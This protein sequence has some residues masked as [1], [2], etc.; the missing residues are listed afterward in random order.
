[1]NLLHFDSEQSWIRNVTALWCDR[2]R[3][4]PRLVMC[5]PSGNTPNAIYA[6]MGRSVANGLASFRDAEIFALDDYGGLAAEDPGRCRN[7][8]QRHLLDHIDLPPGRFHFI[9]TE[10][11]DLD[12][13]C[14][15]YTALIESRG[16]F[17]LTLLGIG[18]NG[19]LGLNEPG[20]APES[21]TRRVEMH[22]STVKASAGYLTHANL[23]T[24]G[25]GVGLKHLLASREVWLLANGAKKAEIIRRTVRDG[26]GTE[27]PASLVRRHA[28]SSLLVDDG[29]GRLL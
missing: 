18:L 19:H 22:E 6:G 27:V 9:D 28:N 26:V 8:L 16:G 10:A 20:S 29:A 25:V 4:N 1:M 14:G 24:W 15:D 23:P 13:V 12:R 7:M 21:V 17:D 2:L 3:R 5:L 11:R